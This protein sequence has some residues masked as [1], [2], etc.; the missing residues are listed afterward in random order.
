[1]RVIIANDGGHEPAGR[2]YV[3]VNS[4]GALIDLTHVPGT[5]HDPTI[6]RA[7]WGP[8]VVNGATTEAGTITRQD[9]TKQTF[10]DRNL[11]THYLVAF[12]NQCKELARA[13]AEYDEAHP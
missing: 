8:V 4:H 10:W 6:T 11:L 12:D 5:L 7:E 1:M 9:G 3:A 2:H 13:Q